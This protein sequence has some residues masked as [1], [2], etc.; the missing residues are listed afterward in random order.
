M[1]TIL[2][3]LAWLF[4]LGLGCYALLRRHLR[5]DNHLADQEAQLAIERHGRAVAERALAGSHLSM[6]KMAKQQDKIREGERQRIARD[7]HDDLGQ[8][9]L[10][11]KIDL[12]LL[13]VSTSG[14]HPMVSGKIGAMIGNLDRTICSLRTIIN[15]LRPAA[16][17]AGLRSAMEWQL[18]EFSRINGIAHE[19]HAD[20]EA[21]SGRPDSDRDAVLFRILQ[22]AL[23][24]VVRHA[25]ATDV[26][27]HIKRC[28]GQLMLEIQDNGIGMPEH[29]QGPGC[30]LSGM[31]ER[32]S[33]M[34]GALAI[35]STPGVGTR[36]SLS[37]PFHEHHQ[38]H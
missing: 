33:A 3:A 23:S 18:R 13:Q 1:P 27:V 32:I 20:P 37:I 5:L 19:L 24:N 17:Q 38:A 4:L 30:G 2:L 11:L 15:D 16:L 12:S 21:F 22:E 29:A 6:C 9:L 10:T 8:N 26:T 28:D 7:I 31:R 14:A 34:G 36:L 35:D 25:H